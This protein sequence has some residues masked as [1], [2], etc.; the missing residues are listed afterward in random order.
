[1]KL[2]VTQPRGR[3]GQGGGRAPLRHGGFSGR[4]VRAPPGP[5]RAPSA[6]VRRGAS[7][8]CGS[9]PCRASVAA[10]RARALPLCRGA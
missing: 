10:D 3:A 8:K 5:V 1:M 9:G 6:R 2:R 7:G 4:R